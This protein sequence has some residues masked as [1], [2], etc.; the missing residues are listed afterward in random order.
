M[1]AE[2]PA[3]LA[4]LA[5]A[6]GVDTSY[7]DRLG[8]TRQASA[9]TIVAILRAMGEPLSE[10]R[11]ASACLRAEP[12][13]PP[14]PP[15]A[16]A[17]DGRLGI[18]WVEVGGASKSSEASGGQAL[19]FGLHTLALAPAR[20]SGRRSAEPTPVLVISAPRR[21]RA[22]PG[23]W[24]LFAPTYALRDERATLTGDFTCLQALCG[25]AGRLGASHVSTLPLLA[26]Y[27]AA[28]SPGTPAGPYSPVS[29]MWWNEGYLDVSRVPELAGLDPGAA[30]AAFQS[31][32]PASA[33]VAAAAAALRPLLDV[34][35]DRLRRSGGRR[36]RELETFCAAKDGLRLY[37]L[38]RAAVETGGAQ[39]WRW[40]A[41]LA[42]GSIR[43]G[44]DVPEAA[45]Q[46]HM[47]AQWLCEQQLAAVRSQG[48]ASG[49]GLMLDLP[50]GC[51]PDGFDPWAYGSSFVPAGASGQGEVSVGAPPDR[52]FHAGQ[53]WGFRP[54]SPHG[55]RCGGYP[56]LRACLS[57]LMSHC[58]ALRIDHVMGLQRLWWIPWGAA[59]ADGAYVH[60]PFEEM[61][62]LTC[63][64][65][66]QHN[67]AV[68]GEDLGT[69][70]AEV[71][72]KLG[73]H[74]I[75]GMHVG[76]FDLSTRPGVR[77]APRPSSVACVDTHDTAT[78]AGWFG[79]GDIED[80]CHLGFLT[81][82]AADGERTRRLEA[83]QLAVSRFV[84][85]GLLET[86]D[87]ADPVA[88]HAAVLEELGASEAG[89]VSVNI[90]DLW[91]ETDPQN[92]PGTTTEHANFS[93]RLGYT[94]ADIEGSAAT[95]DPL[96]RLDKARR[97]AKRAPMTG[98]VPP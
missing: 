4:R 41:T 16:V 31:G 6:R 82:A 29:R 15:V 94:L 42:A 30:T 11:D 96:R 95:G 12:A 85:S 98:T 45:V 1:T 9:D 14:V 47:Y 40:G 3:D 55:E 78:F 56:V 97:R 61:L 23:G 50:I 76:V 92:M 24:A 32:P 5:A 77:L 21:T 37:G 87:A 33:D 54:L 48:V 39:P 57:Q 65:A 62:A 13:A 7:R 8:R 27:S 79:G 59:A 67:V 75:A 49:C 84:A 17:W 80:R 25:M 89:L 58:D 69:V 66:W 88:V 63:L 72:S 43:A 38:F 36:L 2:L 90:E 26:G 68:A 91:G 83:R 28:D 52:F 44:R 19:A 22:L 51:L 60:Y 86:A 93:R 46:A 18:E 10:A 53:D 73:D 70:D 71:R 64:Y 20:R 74:G 81:A 35:V 34:G